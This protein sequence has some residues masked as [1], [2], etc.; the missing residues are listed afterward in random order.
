MSA[1]EALEIGYVSAIVPEEELLEAAR[2][3]AT[4][5]LAGSPF[6]HERIK[7]LVYS[8][9]GRE[10]PTSNAQRAADPSPQV[11]SSPKVD[12]PNQKKGNDG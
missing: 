9:L 11:R 6:S 2:A 8:G 4:S 1:E 3:E 5:Y 7:D 12:N 10:L